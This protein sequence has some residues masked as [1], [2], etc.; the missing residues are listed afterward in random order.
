MRSGRSWRLSPDPTRV[1]VELPKQE[2]ATPIR[3]IPETVWRRP[4]LPAELDPRSFLRT[5]RKK[6]GQGMQPAGPASTKNKRNSNGTVT[7]TIERCKANEDLA[8]A[9]TATGR[10]GSARGGPVNARPGRNQRKNYG[11]DH[12]TPVSERRRRPVHEATEGE[13]QINRVRRIM[14]P[15]GK[16]GV[17]RRTRRRLNGMAVTAG[18]TPLPARDQFTRTL[19]LL[20]AALR[21]WE[22]KNAHQQAPRSWRRDFVRSGN[23]TRP[24]QNQDA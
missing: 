1:C 11:P 2:A 13:A 19:Q 14:E 22:A 23:G 21:L 18:V 7:G 5:C 10:R 8:G 4:L 15:K 17:V 24:V 6:C 9:V 12:G 16:K 3:K 20:R